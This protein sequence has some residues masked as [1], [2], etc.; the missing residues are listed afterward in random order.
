MKRA[1]KDGDD[2]SER[3]IKYDA[4]S[5]KEATKRN[6]EGGL[7]FSREARTRQREELLKPCCTGTGP[8]TWIHG[9]ECHLIIFSKDLGEA[10]PFSMQGLYQPLRAASDLPFK[11]LL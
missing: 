4:E 1:E 11:A 6:P 2:K 7:S 9:P 5:L 8:C 10:C 3:G